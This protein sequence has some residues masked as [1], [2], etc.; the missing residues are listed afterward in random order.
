MFIC[1]VDKCVD[2]LLTSLYC[3]IIIKLYVLY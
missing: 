3:I 1:I 2:E